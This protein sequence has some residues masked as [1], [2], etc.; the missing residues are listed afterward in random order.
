[1]TSNRWLQRLNCARRRRR[2][3]HRRPSCRRT[4]LLPLQPTRVQGIVTWYQ[5]GLG[6][7]LRGTDGSLWVQTAQMLDLQPG[8]KVEALGLSMP[9]PFRP[10]LQAMNVRP[11]G[12]ESPPAALRLKVEELFTGRQQGELVSVEAEFVEAFR[13]AEHALI[14][15]LRE[16]G[17]LLQARLAVQRPGEFAL[18]PGSRVRVTG[19]CETR[20]ARQLWT[21][22]VAAGIEIQLRSAADVELLARPR[23]WTVQRLLPVLGL[24]AAALAL[25]AGWVMALRR[26]VVAQTEIIRQKLEREAIWEER[27]RIAQDLHD[28]VGASLT[29]ISLLGELVRRSGAA[30]EPAQQQLGK[31][32]A[33]ARETVRALDEIVWTVNPRNDTLPRA[34]S[35]IANSVHDLLQDTGTRCRLHVPDDLPERMLNAKVR[36]H[37]Y[38]AVKEAVRNVL[39]HARATELRLNLVVSDAEI[40]V[41]LADNGCG[42][43]LAA[44]DPA[45][46]GL[47]NL[48]RRLEDVGGRFEIQSQPGQGTQ[49]NLTVPLGGRIA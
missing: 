14:L 8:A 47:T 43:D 17:R 44:V 42:F 22:Q 2:F 38:L 12:Q 40:A 37:L 11:L 45:R 13:G 33:K 3:A 4:H 23:W 28:D 5:R 9:A 25:A 39:K 49:V 34:A 27:T 19:I 21:P 46:N 6:L 16:A 30:A 10:F 20:A 36:H 1:M 24:L 18:A 15:Q 48:R 41:T 31:I 29:Q 26:R 35:Y 32:T 7:Y